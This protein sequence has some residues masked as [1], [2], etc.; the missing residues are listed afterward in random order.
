MS[1]EALSFLTRHPYLKI[2]IGFSVIAICIWV[3]CGTVIYP[4][5][6]SGMVYVD[7]VFL[8]HLSHRLLSHISSSTPIVA[9]AWGSEHRQVRLLG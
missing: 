8:Q 7:G 9:P 1:G 3:H 5:S 6:R 2:S 4:T